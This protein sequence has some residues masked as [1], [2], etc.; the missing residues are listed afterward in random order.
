MC[1]MGCC[2]K[3]LGNTDLRCLIAAEDDIYSTERWCIQYEFDDSKLVLCFDCLIPRVK[4]NQD[5]L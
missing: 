2:R 5:D 1:Q 3:S 4:R